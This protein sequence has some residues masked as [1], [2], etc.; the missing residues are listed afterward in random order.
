MLYNIYICFFIQNA[1]QIHQSKRLYSSSDLS[2]EDVKQRVLD[3]CRAFDKIN[4]DKVTNECVKITSSMEHAENIFHHNSNFMQL[5]TINSHIFE[6]HN[7]LLPR[8]FVV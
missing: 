4:A 8:A 1:F 6:Y 2:I 7:L 3:V 5:V